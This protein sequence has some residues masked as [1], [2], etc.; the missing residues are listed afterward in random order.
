LRLAAGF[1]DGQVFAVEA[2]TPEVRTVAVRGFYPRERDADWAWRWMGEEAAWTIVNTGTGPI[3]ATLDLELSAFHRARHMTLLL[4]GHPVQ[5]IVVKPTY[6]LYQF[7]PLTV[8][9]GLHELVFQP[10]DTA[11]VA[12]DV[13]ESGDRRRLSFALGTWNWTV[14]GR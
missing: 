13:I 12:G 8:A 6:R 7:G 10:T 5:S 14:R 3:V 11:T 9:P 2:R 4:D 1:D